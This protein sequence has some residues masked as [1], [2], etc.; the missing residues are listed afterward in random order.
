[1]KFYDQLKLFLPIKKKEKKRKSY[2]VLEDNTTFY[3]IKKN[4][5]NEMS[6]RRVPL[7]G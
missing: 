2:R 1:M 7:F 3:N 5:L 4:Y 6:N